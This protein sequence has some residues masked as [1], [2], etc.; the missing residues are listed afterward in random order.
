M[1]EGREAESE[2]FPVHLDVCGGSLRNVGTGRMI[3]VSPY[4]KGETVMIRKFLT[5]AAVLSLG[6]LGGCAVYEVPGRGP[7]YVQPGY[8]VPVYAP[9]YYG[10]W[11]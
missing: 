9:P 11:R 8:A 5:V 3:T 1:G 4:S 7:A 10:H 2:N 6:A